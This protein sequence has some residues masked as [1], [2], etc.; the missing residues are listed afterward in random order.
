[1]QASE[2]NPYINPFRKALESGRP[3]AGIWSMLNSS[4]VVEGLGWA[5]F[6]WLLIDAEHSPVS[7]ADAT[8][9]LRAIS[10]S[11]TVPI[12]RPA[13]NDMVLLKQYLD[14]GAQTIM[15][16]YVQNAKEARQAVSGMRYPPDGH[17]GYAG[18]H[19]ASR[20]GY[21]A[22]Y[23]HRA[24]EALFLIVQI[25]T[26]SGLSNVEEI[27]EVNGVDAVFFGP[28]DLSASMGF[29]GK[30]GDAGVTSEIEKAAKKVKAIGKSVGVLAPNPDLASH[31]I[32]AGFDFVS[33]TT[34]AALLFGQ[35]RATS[36]LYD[37][38]SVE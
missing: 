29:L 12:V 24:A 6:D 21:D 26:V 3:L 31:Y 14:I 28:G 13:W 36:K 38:A 37:G 19:R 15:L 25:E 30:P 27:A 9:H 20:F 35:A 4:N 16:P 17:R 2:F 18:M 32:S 1:M 8:S 7:L 11:P 22:D 10:N 33:V 5:G 34:D 23:V